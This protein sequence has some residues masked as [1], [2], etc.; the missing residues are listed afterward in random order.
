MR[1]SAICPTCS[2]Y[3]NALCI[4]YNGTS[5][6]NTGITTLDS[7]ETALTKIN[8]SLVPKTGTVAP[9]MSAVYI[10]QLYVNTAAPALY[11]AKSVGMGAGD[12]ILL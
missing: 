5:L 3:Y 6:T 12:W 7:L 4:L 10:G 11:Y 2:N 8:D 9:T 1:T